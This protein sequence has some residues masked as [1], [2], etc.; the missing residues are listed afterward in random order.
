MSPVALLGALA[1]E[2]GLP[3]PVVLAQALETMDP[4]TLLRLSQDTIEVARA[5]GAGT[6]RVRSTEPDLSRGWSATQPRTAVTRIAV[7]A[8]QTAGLLLFQGTALERAA[9]TVEQAVAG[10]RM[11]QSLAATALDNIDEVRAADPVNLLFGVT[12]VRDRLQITLVLDALWRSLRARIASVESALT[13]LRSELA[14]DPT[15]APDALRAGPAALTPPDPVMNPAYRTDQ[16]NH[17]LLASDLNSRDPQR[18]MFAMSILQSLE[19]ATDRGGV[20]DLVV[21]DSQAFNGQ[22]RAAISVGD[23]TTATNV[24]V[25]VPGVSSS[26]K[27]MRGGINAAGDL[28]DEANRQD[29]GSRTAVVAWYGYDIP[30]SRSHDIFASPAT[31]VSNSMAAASS[32][33]AVNAGPILAADLASIKAMSQS[34]ARTTLI[35]FSM[36]STVVSEAARYPLPVEALVMLGSPGAGPDTRSAGSYPNIPAADVY[37]L[38]YAQDPVTREITDNLAG[39][40]SGSEPFGPDPASQSFG[41]NHIDATTNVPLQQPPTGQLAELAFIAGTVFGDP[42]HHSMDNYMKGG[43]LTAEGSIVTGRR[44]KVPTK[45]GR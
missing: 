21:Y 23:L 29:P 4:S 17:A 22:G 30:L 19:L 38:S 32:A 14:Q 34:S 16:A 33:N 26:P 37:S 45:P 2:L 9:Q 12:N 18:M 41:G 43:A 40:F 24:A 35:G 27:D 7:T 13:T 31:Y 42:R 6:D 39:V 15:T 20:A 11:D 44:D 36:G 28:R 10:G 5:V 8:D 25:V 3:N 1:A